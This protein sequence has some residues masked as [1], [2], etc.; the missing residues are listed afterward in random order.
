MAVRSPLYYN[1]GNLQEMSTAMVGQIVDQIVYQ[2]SLN[3]SVALS[4]VGS[5][6]SLASMNDTRL[7]AGAASTSTTAFPSEATTAEPSVVTVT[8]DK[9]TETRATVTPTSDTGKLWPAYYNASGNIQAMNLQDVKDTFLHPAI[10]LLAAGTLTTQQAGTYHINSSTTVSGSA[11][12]SGSNTAVFVNTEADTSLYTAGGIAETQ[13]QPKTVTS[14]YLH[15]ITGSDTSYTLPISIDASNNLQSFPEATFESL[16]QEWIRYTA[17][18]STDGYSLSYNVGT[19]GSGNTR[20][21]GMVDTKLNSSTYA[22]LQVN[23]DD[24]RTQEF[25]S[26]SAVAQNTYYLRILKS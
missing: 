14:F 8:Y 25:P 23:T 2:Y 12:V 4:V 18:S 19:S 15:R 13:D 17:V 5:S 16:F 10:D 22:T 6:G 24:Y 7:Q 20:G 21:T 11:E 3:P 1:A 26:G 9:I